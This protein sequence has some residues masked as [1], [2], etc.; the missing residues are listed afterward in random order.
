MAVP[1]TDRLRARVLLRSGQRKLEAYQAWD[2]IAVAAPNDVEAWVALGTLLAAADLEQR[3]LDP[4]RSALGCLER[5]LTLAPANVPARIALGRVYVQRGELDAARLA[6]EA[7]S[8]A[9]TRSQEAFACLGDL[10]LRIATDGR[11]IPDL[12][13]LK[14]AAD[15]YGAALRIHERDAAGF[16]VHASMG[17]L[18]LARDNPEGALGWF[19]R[20]LRYTGDPRAKGRIDELE[21]RLPGL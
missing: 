1:G 2:A 12:P 21:A 3:S 5:A 13:G 8:K 17:E 20:Q 19:R 6:F 11:A 9:D 7:A 10:L 4:E 14:H 15:A 16:R 18:E